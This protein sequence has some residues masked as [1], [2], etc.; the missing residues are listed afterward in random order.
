MCDYKAKQIV[1]M[2]GHYYKVHGTKFC[3]KSLIHLDCETGE[4][5]ND[6]R[7][8]AKLIDEMA[9]NLIKTEIDKNTNNN[10]TS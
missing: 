3:S 5:V 4:I 8:G 2:K 9:G 7:Q 1:T 6:P 10:S